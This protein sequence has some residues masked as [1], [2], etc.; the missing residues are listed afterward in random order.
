MDTATTVQLRHK[1]GQAKSCVTKGIEELR[2]L[3]TYG[4]EY[5]AVQTKLNKLR[6]YLH[7]LEVK[8]DEYLAQ[9]RDS[10]LEGEEDYYEMVAEEVS[11]V[12]GE[13]SEWAQANRPKDDD[14]ESVASSRLSRQSDISI[15]ELRVKASAKKAALSAQARAFKELQELELQ[16]LQ[17]KHKRRAIE[18]EIGLAEAEAEVTASSK[19]EGGENDIAYTDHSRHLGVQDGSDLN[20]QAPE[21]RPVTQVVSGLANQSSDEGILGTVGGSAD[22]Q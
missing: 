19:L 18:L 22:R 9:I 4:G 14:V 13:V 11:R 7:E 2:Q 21:W 10:D 1:R 16:E 8:H 20:P 17:C 12:E 15:Q 6:E 3:L 5:D